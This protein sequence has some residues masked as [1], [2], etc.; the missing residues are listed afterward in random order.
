MANLVEGV[1]AIDV[2]PFGSATFFLLSWDPTHRFLLLIGCQYFYL[3]TLV[4]VPIFYL[5]ISLES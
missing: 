3:L 1:D 4:I 2:C 5:S